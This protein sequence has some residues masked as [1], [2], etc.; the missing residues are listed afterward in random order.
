[1]P[2]VTCHILDTTRGVPAESVTCAI[3]FVSELI[4]NPE[5]E[6]SYDVASSKPFAMGKT[7]KDGR[8]TNWVLNPENSKD[9]NQELGFT[10]SNEWSTL[11]SGNYKIKFLT[12]QYFHKL[13]PGPQART[14]FPF[15][16][17]YFTVNNPPDHHYHIPLLLSNFSYT[18]YRGS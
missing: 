12:G 3:Y 4:S 6:S 17:I 5:E 7:N 13:G 16:E 10:E 8:I 1:M 2:P 18:T 15:V 14:F 11:K 9:T